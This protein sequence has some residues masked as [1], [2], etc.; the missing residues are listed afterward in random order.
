MVWVVLAVLYFTGDSFARKA[1]RLGSRSRR[2]SFA[3]L[4]SSSDGNPQNHPIVDCRL[5]FL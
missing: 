5:A 3:L 2:G 4:L 1:L